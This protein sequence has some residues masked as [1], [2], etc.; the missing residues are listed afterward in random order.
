MDSTRGVRWE[1]SQREGSHR[2]EGGEGA[3]TKSKEGSQQGEGS[4]RGHEAALGVESTTGG[5]TGG[6]GGRES[7]STAREADGWEWEEEEALRGRGGRGWG[8]S[9][10]REPVDEAGA[11]GG[12]GGGREGAGRE[13]LEGGGIQSGPCPPAG[14]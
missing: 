11:R 14:P 3:V 7:G 9:T 5:C 13:D 1:G 12:G 2:E 8:G 6:K 4:H 10:V